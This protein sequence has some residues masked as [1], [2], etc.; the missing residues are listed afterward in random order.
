[1]LS[2][3]A[4]HYRTRHTRWASLYRGAELRYAAGVRM[5]L[6]PGD[7]I[8]GYLAFTGIY[9]PTL[10]RRVIQLAKSGGT[11]VDVGANLGYFSLLWAAA[12]PANRCF[13]FEASPRNIN[14]LQRNV[15]QNGFESRIDVIPLAAG[16]SA[17]KLRFDPGPPDQTGW[18]GF[19]LT[20]AGHAV[21]VDVVRVDEMVPA[22]SHIALLKVD[23]EGADAWAIMGCDRFLKA[24]AVNEVWYEQYKPRMRALGIPE[25]AA[26]DYLRSVGYSP[27]PES[28][29]F[30]EMVE[31]SAVPT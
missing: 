6:V 16:K 10:T 9:E 28:D 12:N 24:R 21:E 17:G 4:R 20:R 30:G 29:T 3:Y 5:D 18:G 11:F 13:A 1:M 7:A 27:K 19:T 26:Q 22:D 31:W 2:V 23:I 25:D 15:R 14:F 8:S